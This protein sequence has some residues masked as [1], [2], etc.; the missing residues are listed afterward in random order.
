MVRDI[1]WAAGLFEGEGH[2]GLETVPGRTRKDGTGGERRYCYPRLRMNLT[3]LE[4]IEAFVA[5]VGGTLS[6][7]H[8]PRGT[9]RKASWSWSACGAVA[10]TIAIQFAPYLGARRKQRLQEVFDADF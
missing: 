5:V 3:D 4:V 1:A 7:P 10:R 9:E 6:G 8:G 2:I